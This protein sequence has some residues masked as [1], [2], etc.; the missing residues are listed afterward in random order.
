MT[1]GAVEYAGAVYGGPEAAAASAG[2]A[3]AVAVEV[4]FGS[5]PGDTGQLWTDISDYLLEISTR[6]GRSTELDRCPAGTA[7]IIL[8][9]EDRRFDPTHTG[10]PYSP[11]VVP[12]RRARIRGTYAG[13]TYD[14]FNGY[15]DGW[16]QSYQH[17]SVAACELSLIDAFEV[18]ANITLLSSPYATEV[19]ADNP[20]AWYRLGE[21]ASST[22]FLD[23]VSTLHVPITLAPTL[24]VAGLIT[25]D[26]DTAATFTGG[27]YQG[28]QRLGLPSVTG[29]PLT[30]E[31]ILKGP[32]AGGTSIYGE[33][34][35]VAGLKGWTVQHD[36]SSHVQL[37]VV[38]AAGTG[39]VTTT[40]TVD[41]SPHHVA[42]TWAA[43]GTLTAYFDGMAQAS[44]YV[45][46]GTFPSTVYA[47]MGGGITPF[48]GGSAAEGTYDEIVIYPTALSAARLLAHSQARA[49]AWSGDRSGA[50][51]NRIL[52]AAGWPTAD[53]QIDTG[54]AILQG[55]DLATTALAALQKIEETE[56]GRLFVQA[57]GK[58]RFI[59]RDKL[60][61]A[62]YTTSQGEFGDS[63]SELEYAEL[64]YRY[65][66]STIVNE[67]QVSRS[68][69]TVQ[70]ARDATS[71]AKYLR[72]TK[73][74]DGLL[75][76]S[77]ATSLDLANWL[78]AHYKNPFQRATG[79]KLEPDAGNA[80]THYPQVLGRELA[81]RV[82][83]RRRPQQVGSA[84]D[85]QVRVE[86]VRHR[87]QGMEWK[88]DWDVSPADTD[89]YGIW[90]DPA[91]LW[92]TALW[93]F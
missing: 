86:A 29:P 30:F 47:V 62:P 16:Q 91:S 60:N 52:D 40:S 49:T 18:L 9:N 80:T 75:H 88:V 28:G 2:L 71:E 64:L 92:D 87:L 21:P 58:V 6:R 34:Y 17:P 85:Q 68:N 22:L 23:N 82:I 36:G 76:Q 56:Q 44:T 74:L 20:A 78:V 70:I 10:S 19:D 35:D 54:A 69:G 51:I 53:R 25:R 11:N 81:D 13:V 43:D 8:A 50:R 84:I 45:A 31:M 3:P 24:G 5:N 7:Q 37:L 79:V 67:A 1:Y 14:I 59:S 27:T 66:K 83:V 72:R 38:T 57:D 39:S 65:D 15:A 73:T 77:D 32:F 90:D 46:A 26:S 61:Q 89:V 4:A 63:G 55:A 48:S 41:S 33:I 12:M 93:S 42:F